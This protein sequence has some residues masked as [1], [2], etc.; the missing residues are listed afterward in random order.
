[1]FFLQIIK[2][3][4]YCGICVHWNYSCSK[5]IDYMYILL[6]IYIIAINIYIFKG[7]Y[8]LQLTKQYKLFDITHNNIWIHM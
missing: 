4:L 6:Y 5:H 2:P 8:Y 7:I 3:A 1:M